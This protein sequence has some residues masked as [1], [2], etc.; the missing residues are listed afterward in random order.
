MKNGFV[1]S[2]MVARGLGALTPWMETVCE[3]TMKN[4]FVRPIAD[5]SRQHFIHATTQE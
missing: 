5:S 2:I 4:G 3:E 1:C